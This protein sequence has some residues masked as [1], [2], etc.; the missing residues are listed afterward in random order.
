M[1]ILLDCDLYFKKDISL[2]FKQFEKYVKYIKNLYC[3]IICFHFS[4]KST[5]LFG[6]APELTPV[7]RHILH[8]YKAKHNT[9]FGEFYHNDNIANTTHP[10]GF[11]GYNSGVVLLNFKAQRKSKDFSIVIKNETVYNLTSKYG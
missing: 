4:F 5:A 2:L 10:K 7:Y 8:T 1:A 11:Q 9:T 3:T 6:L